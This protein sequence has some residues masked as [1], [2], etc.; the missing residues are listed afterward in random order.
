MPGLD[1]AMIEREM[2]Y[3]DICW[4]SEKAA[5]MVKVRQCRRGN[6]AGSHADHIQI[7]QAGAQRDFSTGQKS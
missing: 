4:Q 1:F 5:K 3:L 2:G 7:D 6:R